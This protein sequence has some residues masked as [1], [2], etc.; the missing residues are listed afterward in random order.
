VAIRR[1]PRGKTVLPFVP[2]VPYARVMARYLAVL[3]DKTFGI[4]LFFEAKDQQ[5]AS[6]FMNA[7]PAIVAGVMTAELHPFSVALI[8]KNP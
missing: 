5:A 6:E 3:L 1:L 7:D 4:V 2:L 8:R